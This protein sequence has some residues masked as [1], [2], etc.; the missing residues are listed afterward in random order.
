MT[1]TFNIYDFYKTMLYNKIILIY[2]GAFDQEMVKSVISM[3]EKKLIHDNTDEILRKKLFNIMVESLQNICKHQL[4]SDSIEN[5]PFLIISNSD[6]F[7]EVVTGNLIA[8]DKISIV[9]DKIDHVNS[10]S[11]DEL[12][13]YYKKARLNSVIS[14]VGGAGL[15]FIDIVRKA[16]NPLEYQFYDLGTDFSFFIQKSKIGISN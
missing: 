11:A 13:D 2:Q 9:Q 7:F 4:N 3:T 12:K 8:N 6:G 14:S 16:G 1:T 5:S 10:L 15:G